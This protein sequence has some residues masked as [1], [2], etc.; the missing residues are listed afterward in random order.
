MDKLLLVACYLVEI[1]IMVMVSIGTTVLLRR[2]F[3]PNETLEWFLSLTLIV[4]LNLF[5]RYN[6]EFRPTNIKLF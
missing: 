6:H 4:L 2:F 5:V 3:G 1:I